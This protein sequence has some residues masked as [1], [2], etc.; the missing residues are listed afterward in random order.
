MGGMGEAPAGIAVT[1]FVAVLPS[2]HQPYTDTCLG[3]MCPELR[4]A[5]LVVD[6]TRHNRGVPAS[7]NLGIDRM[8]SRGSEWLVIVSAA[9]RFGPEGGSDLL[10]AL[11]ATTFPVVEAQYV[12]WHLIAFHR[13]VFA[14]VGRFDENFFPGYWEDCDYGYRLSLAYDLA[15]PFWTKTLVNVT[16]ESFAHGIQLAGVEVDPEKLAAYYVE[17]WGGPPS[18]ETYRVPFGGAAA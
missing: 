13:N 16:L 7:W 14:D 9:C 3:S 5:T 1:S 11:E 12:G 17:K 6:N 10:A 18:Q 15:P 8:E 4:D 2:I